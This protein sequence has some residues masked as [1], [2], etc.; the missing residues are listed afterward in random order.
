[1]HPIRTRK[2]PRGPN[3][4]GLRSGEMGRA[5]QEGY[6]RIGT[7]EDDGPDRR[8]SDQAWRTCRKNCAVF[9]AFTPKRFKLL[10]KHIEPS[11]FWKVRRNGT[12]RKR[13]GT[14]SRKRCTSVAASVFTVDDRV[15]GRLNGSA[16]C[17][18][19]CV[20]IVD[21]GGVHSGSCSLWPL[22]ASNAAMLGP[23]LNVSG[24]AVECCPRASPTIRAGSIR[25]ALAVS[26]SWKHCI[27]NC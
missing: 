12:L 4:G 9:P 10:M 13:N 2:D 25:Q 3:A 15:S 6:F 1:V 21:R 19:G 14:P 17:E 8:H 5:L 23:S 7:C 16:L 20:P 11:D 22:N 18:R 26:R 27:R 24:L